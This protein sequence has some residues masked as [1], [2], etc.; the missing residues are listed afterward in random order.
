MFCKDF[1]KK[2]HMLLF[3]YYCCLRISSFQLQGIKRGAREREREQNSYSKIASLTLVNMNILVRC[4]CC[5]NV[6][7]G[8]VYDVMVIVTFSFSHR[9][10][11]CALNLKF[12]QLLDVT[13][14]WTFSDQDSWLP[15]RKVSNAFHCSLFSI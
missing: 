3:W 1:T 12:S 14:H 8:Y 11:L 6:F 15:T 9:S 2:K 5:W 10:N 7:A 4:Y 13:F